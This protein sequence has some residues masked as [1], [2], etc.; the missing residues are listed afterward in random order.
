M[1]NKTEIV[2]N[3]R[4]DPEDEVHKGGVWK[5]AHADFMTAMMAFFLVMWLINQTDPDTRASVANYFNP[6]NLS[7][8]PVEY[9]G[10]EK[11][12]AA[13]QESHLAKEQEGTEPGGSAHYARKPR[14][15][16]GA[17]FQDPYAILARIASESDAIQHDALGA[18]LLTGENDTP[19]QP[20]GDIARDPFDPLYWQVSRMSEGRSDG[21][22]KPGTIPDSKGEMNVRSSSKAPDNVLKASVTPAQVAEI[23]GPPDPT[24][25]LT[26]DGVE[27]LKQAVSDALKSAGPSASMPRVDVQKVDGGTLISLTDN[28]GFSMFAIGSAEPHPRVV[29]AMAGIGKSIA[30]HKG[31]VVIRGHTDSRPFRSADYDNWRLSQARAQMAV[32]M[33]VRGGL[34]DKR[35]ARVEGHAD[36]SPLIKDDGN[37]DANRRIEILIQE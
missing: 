21:I 25:N 14:F 6:V 9:K 24:Q 37:A 17:L 2:V 29:K 18:D 1:S 15:K 30:G 36:R 22:V 5:I 20:G 31:S 10:L 26:P 34:A 13:S 12:K 23:S 7:Q 16:E 4:V 33:L 19:G 3:R 27:G 11:P 28:L 32:Y 35:I 8:S